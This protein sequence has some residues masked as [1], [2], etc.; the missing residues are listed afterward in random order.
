MRDGIAVA[1][2]G[3]PAVALVT[4]LF[5]PQ[6]RFVA[7][8]SGMST[9]PQVLLP[10]PVAGSGA[11]AMATLAAS[12]APRLWETLQGRARDGSS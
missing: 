7:K 4:T 2:R 1:Q 10:H 8:A 6:G 12:L 3:L 11:E 9:I 5:E